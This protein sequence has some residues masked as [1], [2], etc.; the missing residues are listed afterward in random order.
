[1]SN[2]SFVPVCCPFFSEAIPEVIPKRPSPHRFR[3]EPFLIIFEEIMSPKILRM[4]RKTAI[5][6]DPEYDH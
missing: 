1:M 5:N 2:R 4:P 6:P 3:L